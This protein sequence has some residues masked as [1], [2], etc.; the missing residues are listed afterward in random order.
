MALEFSKTKIC[1]KCRI[2]EKESSVYK[3]S[4]Q[5]MSSVA[6]EEKLKK[7]DIFQIWEGPYFICTICHDVFIQGLC[8][9]FL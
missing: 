7:K 9:F 3:L 8:G 5:N 4:A 2:K 1:H 6:K